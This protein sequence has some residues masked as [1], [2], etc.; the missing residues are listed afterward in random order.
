MENTAIKYEQ[1]HL[2]MNYATFLPFGTRANTMNNRQRRW[3]VARPAKAS[4]RGSRV[5]RPRVAVANGLR[6]VFIGRATVAVPVFR[7]ASN[8]PYPVFRALIAHIL[9][10]KRS[11]P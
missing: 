6:P 5:V 4:S 10:F 1:F 3:R 8:P 2:R 11:P 9:A 7:P